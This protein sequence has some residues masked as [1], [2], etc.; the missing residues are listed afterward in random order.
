MK[1]EKTARC[2][3]CGEPNTVNND[4]SPVDVQK[5][6]GNPGILL[7]EFHQAAAY[8]DEE[9][10]LECLENGVDVN[11]RNP[12]FGSTALMLAAAGG[13][14]RIAKLLL[15]RGARPDLRD[16]AGRTA[17]QWAIDRHRDDVLE[18]LLGRLPS[19]HR[20]GPLLRLGKYM[21]RTAKQW[22]TCLL[23]K[24][25]R[26][27]EKSWLD[28]AY[29]EIDGT[30]LH[31]DLWRPHSLPDRP[32]PLV[33]LVHGGGW[34][35]GN[36]HDPSVSAIG[37]GLLGAGFCIAAVDYR[38][39]WKWAFPDPL[40][41]LKAA[42]RHFRSRADE[43]GIAPDRIGVY[44]H[45]AGA[46]LALLLGLTSAHPVLDRCGGAGPSSSVRAVCGISCP[47][48]FQTLLE[49]AEA[50][51]TAVA[52][53]NPSERKSILSGLADRRDLASVLDG[54]NI[55]DFPLCLRD[56]SEQATA[57]LWQ[58]KFKWSNPVR[59]V[60]G[61]VHN[62]EEEETDL[63][64]KR[65]ELLLASPLTHALRPAVAGPLPA[66]LLLH[67]YKD[68]LIP[69]DGC[70]RFHDALCTHG[71]GV[72]VSVNIDPDAEHWHRDAY[73]LVPEFF[74]RTLGFP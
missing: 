27:W 50:L 38:L 21:P 41:D 37:D 48:D 43:F 32:R 3:H 63:V 39:A 13:Y 9:R 55:H 67:G 65:E 56:L 59:L 61:L 1:I 73:R 36:R 19:V 35:G 4:E 68:P 49:I 34:D 52:T 40:E 72:D 60:R 2:P 74:A 17:K 45:S 66:F 5:I 64:P 20:M 22:G 7:W 44:G 29:R 11:G 23:G 14:W 57:R 33:I 24:T 42:V 30:T 18:L 62:T 15:D 8:G 25:R 6:R 53:N 12:D 47:C 10:V 46:H 26:R 51:R 70:R 31:Y 28:Q 16:H 69:A 58:E 71:Q 54:M